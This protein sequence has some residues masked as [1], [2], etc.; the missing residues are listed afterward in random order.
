MFWQFHVLPKQMLGISTFDVAQWLKTHG[1]SYSVN[2]TILVMY[3]YLALGNISRY[4]IHRPS[5]GPLLY[6]DMIGKTLVIDM[7]TLAKIKDG[8]IQ[9]SNEFLLA[10]VVQLAQIFGI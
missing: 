2:N 7:G 6:K 8:S 5:M 3:A 4:G 1:F 10:M 9:V